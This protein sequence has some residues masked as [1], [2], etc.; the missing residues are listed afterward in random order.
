MKLKMT[1]FN[2]NKGTMRVN[3]TMFKM[4]IYGTLLEKYAPIYSINSI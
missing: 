3:I 1:I 4:L 2:F